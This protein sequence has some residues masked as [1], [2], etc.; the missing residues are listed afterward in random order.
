MEIIEKLN[1]ALN[2]I[3]SYIGYAKIEQG[4]PKIIIASD[5]FNYTNYNARVGV[6]KSLLKENGVNDIDQYNIEYFVMSEKEYKE[7]ASSPTFNG[8]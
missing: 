7:A 2:K 4:K 3:D 8:I 1:K 5:R 6:L